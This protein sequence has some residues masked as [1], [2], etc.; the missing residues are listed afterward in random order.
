MF[1]RLSPAAILVLPAFADDSVRPEP[2]TRR[3][4][5]ALWAEVLGARV[6]DVAS[7]RNLAELG[8]TALD[9]LRVAARLRDTFGVSVAPGDLVARPT[10]ESQVAMLR[11]RL[12]GGHRASA[13]R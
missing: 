1:E 11:R 4:V 5:A 13:L 3:A 8:A 12:A 2:V 6:R 7:D 9:T 10:V